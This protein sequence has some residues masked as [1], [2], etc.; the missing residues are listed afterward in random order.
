[1]AERRDG[2]DDLLVLIERASS[3]V[4]QV[5][6][7]SL[8]DSTIETAMDLTNARFGALG[9]VD[10]RGTIVEFHHKGVTELD[11]ERIGHPPVGRGVLGDISRHGSIVRVDDITEHVGYTGMPGGHPEM[12]SFLGVPVKARGRIFGNLYVTEKPGGF[13]EQDEITMTALAALAGTGIDSIRMMQ[14]LQDT[15]VREDRDRIARDV[16][17]SIIQNLFA[18]GLGLQARAFATSDDPELRDALD[19]ASVAIDASIADLRRL[20]YD[21]HGDLPRRGSVAEEVAELAE[22]LGAP[23]DVRVDVVVNGSVPELD[24]GIIDDVLQ[25]V[26]ESV[27]NALRHSGATSISVSLS[28][29]DRSFVLTI[30][31]NGDGFDVASAPWGLGLTNMRTRT[32][33]AGG[34]LSIESSH[35]SGTSVKAQIPLLGASGI[36]A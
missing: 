18:V 17:D 19:D 26:R 5:D 15:A 3:I 4:E 8:L 20:I 13:D 11:M 14:E 36:H 21:L 25:I 33:R 27:S 2:R 34:E 29:D 16:H 1:M 24:V 32:M 9:V 35:G 12:S 31:D 23:Y 10:E 7:Q 30:E 22:R 28:V 6:L